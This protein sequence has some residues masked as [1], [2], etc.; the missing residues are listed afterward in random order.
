[1]HSAIAEI[2]ED[3]FSDLCPEDIPDDCVSDVDDNVN[4]QN[5]EL[6]EAT[7]AKV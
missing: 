4:A 7:V 2:N 3:F 6:L 5:Y 1:M